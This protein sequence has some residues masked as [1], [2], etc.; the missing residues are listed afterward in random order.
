MFRVVERSKLSLKFGNETFMD[1]H[2]SSA[3]EEDDEFV[4]ETRTEILLEI[5][6]LFFFLEI[7][8]DDDFFELK[9]DD[10]DDDVAFREENTTGT[11]GFVAAAANILNERDDLVFFLNDAFARF[12]SSATL[13]QTTRVSSVH[14]KS[15]K[16]KKQKKKQRQRV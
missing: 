5:T 9:K 8:V 4:A 12:A 7:D 2:L 6:T 13:P 15:E 1:C 14:A 10:F 16:R 11:F 3:E